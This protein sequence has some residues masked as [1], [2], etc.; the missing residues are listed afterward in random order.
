MGMTNLAISICS[1]V[2][3]IASFVFTFCVHKQT[4]KRN[5][6]KDTLDAF[7]L[8]QEQVLDELYNIK[9][10]NVNVI[11]EDIH[12]KE[13]KHIS[14]MMAR[15]EHFAVGV[16]TNIYDFN[17]VKRLAGR[18]FCGLFDKLKPIIDIKRNSNTTEKHYDDFELLYNQLKKVY[19]TKYQKSVKSK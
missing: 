12:S 13:F 6:K 18:H 8:L 2:V 1:A 5:K 7:S 3:A 15:I 10:S 17:I 16:N 9:K 19:K 11:A 4:K 14:T